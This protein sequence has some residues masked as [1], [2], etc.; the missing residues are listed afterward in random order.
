M[1]K[2]SILLLFIVLVSIT[3][4]AQ[5]ADAV[6]DQYLDFNYARL[7]QENQNAQALGE[8]ILPNAA[9]LP[10]KSRIS[11]YN[12]LAKLYEDA[13]QTDKAISYYEIVNKAEPDFYVAHRALGYLYLLPAAGVFTKLNAA[14]DKA[15]KNTLSTQYNALVRKALPHLEK[16]QACD[17]SDETLTVIKTLYAN[18][19]DKAG[20]KTLNSKLAAMSK[21]CIEILSE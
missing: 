20:L 4:K 7:K 9:L 15:T 11:F 1:I 3:A 17:P 14:T 21:N 5:T 12:G 19:N 16:A 13:G 8:K 10:A 18:I 6:F 2:K